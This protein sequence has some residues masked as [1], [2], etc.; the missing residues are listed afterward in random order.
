MVN[1]RERQQRNEFSEP[2]KKR[3]A[4]RDENPTVQ[5]E[6]EKQI[7]K[8]KL[9]KA[10]RGQINPK[11]KMLLMSERI[12]KKSRS[13]DRIVVFRDTSAMMIIDQKCE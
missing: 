8:I 6:S 12:T 11:T 10:Y 2:R 4:F 7:L 5:Y 3:V 9:E 13:T 1:F